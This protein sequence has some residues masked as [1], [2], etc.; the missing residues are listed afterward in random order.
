[1]TRNKVQY[2]T[3]LIAHPDR[4]QKTIKSTSK[5]EVRTNEDDI[6]N[7]VTKPQNPDKITGSFNFLAEIE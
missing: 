1:M 7:V 2:C 3:D 5:L 6:E 4:Q